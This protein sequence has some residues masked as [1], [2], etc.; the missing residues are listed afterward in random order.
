VVFLLVG[1]C[2]DV[3]VGGGD[4]GGGG[5]GGGTPT[6]LS[7]CPPM[8]QRNRNNDRECVLAMQNAF[9]MLGEAVAVDGTFG[10][11]TTAAVR[12]FQS[13]KGL[14]VDGIAGSGTLRA[15]E[16]ALP[17]N[18]VFM[19]PGGVFTCGDIFGIC[20]FYFDRPA[21]RI[22]YHALDAPVGLTLACQRL[23]FQARVACSL[24][25]AVGTVVV[26]DAARTAAQNNAC[27]AVDLG[28]VRVRSDN[29]RYCR[30]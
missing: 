20:T 25:G 19:L 27:L 3:A 17:G 8:S 1:G 12:R 26:R 14:T 2:K 9:F 18:R 29:G 13:S 6:T 30:G 7:S 23:K 24:L 28:A 16:S 22:I 10:P 15:L 11:R 4:G 5:G 21:T